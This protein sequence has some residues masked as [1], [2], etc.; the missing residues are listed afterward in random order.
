MKIRSY[1]RDGTL[2]NRFLF[3]H[4]CRIKKVEIPQWT[5]HVNR[6]E[7]WPSIPAHRLHVLRGGSTP[8]IRRW[9]C[10]YLTF[11]HDIIVHHR[12]C[13]LMSVLFMLE[14]ITHSGASSSRA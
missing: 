14:I 5:V 4:I 11:M 10:M 2:L 7:C 8:G 6:F 12:Q 1:G 3:I 9:T 13:A